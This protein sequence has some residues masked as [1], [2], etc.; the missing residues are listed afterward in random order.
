MEATR[1]K[2]NPIIRPDDVAP[3]SEALKVVGVFN[4]AV[5]QVGEETILLMR[6]AEAARETD[7][8][9]VSVPVVDPASR[10]VRVV[11]LPRSSPDVDASDPRLVVHRGRVYLTSVSHLRIARSRDGCR[12]QVDRRPAL[13]PATPYETYGVEDPRI[14]RIPDGRFIVSFSA[15]SEH[16]VCVELAETRDFAEFRRLGIV[17][18]PE[19]RNVALFPEKIGGRYVMMHR[20]NSEPFGSSGIW[21]AFSDDLMHWGDHRFLAGT[22]RGAWDGARIGAGAPPL[23]TP[24]G[25]LAIYHG[26]APGTNAYS[27]G[28]LLLDLDDPT[29]IIARSHEPFLSPKAPYETHGF[30]PN[31]VFACGATCRADGRALVYY[32]AADHVVALAEI[33]LDELVDSLR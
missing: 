12:F 17:L 28:A 23:K 14:T 4:P 6:V 13:A 31:V 26:A 19:N 11:S 5:A 16:G 2:H 33:G 9:Y 15:V 10:E 1:Y 27:L 21:L 22:R 20:P 3:S 7:P 24:H 18:P 8:R 32:G 25:W 29:R 30:Y